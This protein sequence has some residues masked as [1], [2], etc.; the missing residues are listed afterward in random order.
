M[1]SRGLMAFLR[2][3]KQGI[4]PFLGKRCRFDPTCSEYM[5][6]AVERYGALKG[7]WMG[8]K[9]LVRCQPFCRGGYDPVP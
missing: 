3:Y 2:F 7:F 5:Y 4:S 1:A 9:R 6:I 8:L